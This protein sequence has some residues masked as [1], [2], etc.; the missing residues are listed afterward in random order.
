LASVFSV[1]GTFCAAA[2]AHH[3]AKVIV[4]QKAPRRSPEVVAKRGHEQNL[5]FNTFYNYLKTAARQRP[6]GAKLK[7]LMSALLVR[8]VSGSLS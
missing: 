1:T 7:K 5:N 3:K 8:L 6:T 4:I 2:G